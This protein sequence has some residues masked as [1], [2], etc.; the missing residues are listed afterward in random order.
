MLRPTS[1][2]SRGGD[3]APSA[4]PS[5][6]AAPVPGVLRVS[7]L[8]LRGVRGQPPGTTVTLQARVPGQPQLT[9]LS[10][11]QALPPKGGQVAWVGAAGTLA[12]PCAVAQLESIT[13]AALSGAGAELGRATLHLDGVLHAAAAAAA[14]GGARAAASPAPAAAAEGRWYVLE[15]EHGAA[16]GEV[17]ALVSVV[18]DATVAAPVAQPQ[19]QAKGLAR[20][21]GSG[22]AAAAPAGGAAPAAPAP[23]AEA[24]R[25]A[26]EAARAARRALHEADAA[27]EA[28][29]AAAASSS[30]FLRPPP[31]PMR[32]GDYTVLVH[33]IEGRS[34]HPEDREGTSDPY[35]T[36]DIGP[37]PS[38]SPGGAGG[39]ALFP[40]Q[41]QST[42]I[43]KACNDPV[44]D[45][46]MVFQLSA[47]SAAALEDATITL[48]VRDADY[49]SST[50]IG[51]FAFELAALYQQERG[52]EVYRAWV[53][54]M[55][56]GKAEG[57]GSLQ[58]M[59]RVSVA[60]LGPGDVPVPR[61]VRDS[62]REAEE[63]EE[64]ASDA[65]SGS[66]L[67]LPPGVTHAAVREVALTVH[68]GEGLPAMDL[69]ALG[70]LLG[71]AGCDAYVR[72]EMAGAPAGGLRT[73]ACAQA[74]ARDLAVTWLQELT[75]PVALPS[76]ADRIVLSLWDRR[77]VGGG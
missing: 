8:A 52:H 3:A 36:V 22:G 66:Q 77:A 67:R 45:S 24:A 1:P 74:G 26:A 5:P 19:Q 27:A 14:A 58:G 57:A 72:L 21:L 51:S 6:A 38:P 17:R 31:A 32:P 30:A 25:A 60:V 34:L 35:A 73:R 64:G 12:P 9:W 44:F 48:A 65:R 28:A 54:L 18:G 15:D 4:P 37:S 50:L 39:G 42:A 7:S 23:I 55:D 63:G 33:V 40:R 62:A 2:A 69:P 46:H 16:V 76:M 13:L 49:L 41:R 68:Q 59:L 53:G 71:R 75:V 43:H 56:A 11:R 70:G 47:M 20:L 29:A 61:S 10:S